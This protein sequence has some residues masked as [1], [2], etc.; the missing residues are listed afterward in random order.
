MNFQSPDC[1][2]VGGG[3]IGLSIARELAGNGQSVVLMDNGPIGRAAS[4]AGAGILPPSSIEHARHPL[5]ILAAESFRLHS[6]WSTELVEETG[7]D[8]GYRRCG[9]LFIART[10]GEVAALT[11][12][13][14]EWEDSGV[15]IQRLSTEQLGQQMPALERVA[16]A[17][18]LA[19]VVPDEVQ[20]R[21]PDHIRALAASCRQ[22][23]VSIIEN[24]EALQLNSDAGQTTRVSV[25]NAEL[26]SPGKICIAAGAWTAELLAQLNCPISTLPIRGQMV[27][28]KLPA[29]R[30]RQIVYEGTRYIVPRDDGHVLAGS[31]L[32]QAGFDAAVTTDAIADLKSFASSLFAELDEDH[33][34]DAW[35]GLRPAT[36]D[37]FPYMGAVP[38]TANVWAA[39]GHFRSGLL[40]ST[41]TARAM[42]QLMLGHSSV[43]DLSPFRLDRG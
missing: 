7:I 3:V 23:G 27:L 2:V 11:G 10:S 35:A 13:C 39:C 37:G 5:E 43:F 6:L 4:W 33:F 28:Y 14:T 18:Q 17:I 9:A 19:V 1:L 34:V 20:I 22:R 12:Q 26:F 36:W 38:E 29:R 21:N 32:E 30:F 25:R 15:H 40:L 24:V 31:T 8:N 16:G 42:C 41:A